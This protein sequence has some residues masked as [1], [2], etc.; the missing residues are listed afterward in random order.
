MKQKTDLH[1]KQVQ[2]K[3]KKPSDYNVGYKK[4]P[5]STQFPKGRSGN[6]K[7][8]PTGVRNF[9]TDLK[10]E[11]FEMVRVHEGGTTT[12]I[13][14]QKAIVKRAVEKGL[15]GDMRATELVIKWIVSYVGV[16]ETEAATRRLSP[17]DRTILDRYVTS[18]A[19]PN[20][21]TTPQGRAS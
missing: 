21:N 4:P 16:E 8:R 10:E 6:L 17:D 7:G 18:R 12:E 15:K 9:K 20:A 19:K 5:I 14:K 1:K 3:H 2:A 13:S 11:L